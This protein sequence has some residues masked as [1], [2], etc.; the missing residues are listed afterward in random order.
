MKFPILIGMLMTTL[1]PAADPLP[2]PPVAKTDPKRLALHGD[3][4]VD[5]YFW[6]REKTNPAVTGHLNEENAYTA[7]AMK[8]TEALQLKLYG[9]IVGRMKETDLSV[10]VREGD[11]LYYTRT[12][13][14]KQYTIH[15]RKHGGEDAAEEVLLDENE[16]ARGEKYFRLGVFRHSP[17]HNLLAYSTDTSGDEV[18]T[19]RVKD[20]RTGKLLAD[21]VPGV[22]YSLE[23][24]SDN[25]TFFY[26]VVDAAKRPYKLFRH[27]LGTPAADD[28]MVHHETDERFNVEVQRSKSQ[29]Y[30]FLDVHSETTSEWQYLKASTPEAAFHMIFPRVQDVEYDVTHRSSVFYIRIND[31]GKNFRLATTPADRPEKATMRELLPHR[32]DVAIEM[33]EV[34]RDHLVV[35]ERAGGLRH[36]AIENLRSGNKHEV[37]FEEPAYSVS[38]AQ[39]PEFNTT[40]LRFNYTS[41]VTPLSVYDYDMDTKVRTLKKRTEVLG[42]YD[43]AQY[44]SERVFATAHDGVKVP[45]SLVYRKGV[46]RDGSAPLLLYG[47]GSY[48]IT[49]E[50]AFAAERLSLLDRGFVFAIAHIRGSGDMGRYWYEDGKLRKK[51]N[52]FRDFIACAEYLVAQKYTS[53]N[54]LAIQ[55]GSAGGLLMG[56]VLNMRPDLFHAAIAKVPFV[57]VLST[58]LDASLPLTV[59]EYE[60]WGNPN[61][62]AAYEYMRTYS[63]YDNVEAKAYPNLLVT[64][65]LNDP[66]VSYWEPAKWVARLRA[67]KKDGNLLLLKT[68]MGAGHFGPSGRYERFKET[69][70]DY[71]FL[72][73]TMGLPLE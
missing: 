15:C 19:V 50:P 14:G 10:P 60:E 1:L 63:P 33:V 11:W 20:L 35:L 5:P 27:R 55:G 47:Y 73:M 53:R 2:S 58:M 72:L 48:G 68:N 65:G 9:E 51:K 26:N 66:R 39:N 7:A 69:A 41:L 31:K 28:V 30:L 45:V 56:A 57:D 44:T 36:L 8:R 46:K 32:K 23:W 62:Q 38:P 67:M 22:Y 40:E 4:R 64:A 12:E 6:M 16:L 17:D 49:T 42:G 71:A 29:Q 37:S 59:T 18:Y 13:K 61:E 21:V 52:T 24:A 43:A 25:R 34:F 70:F 54:R 3:T